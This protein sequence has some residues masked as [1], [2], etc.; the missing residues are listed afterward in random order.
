MLAAKISEISEKTNELLYSESLPETSKVKLVETVQKSTKKL[1]ED[2]QSADKFPREIEVIASDQS[3]NDAIEDVDNF[4]K[5]KKLTDNRISILKK[6]VQSV[7]Q[8]DNLDTTLNLE[9]NILRSEE[10]LVRDLATIIGK[11]KKEEGKTHDNDSWKALRKYCEYKYRRI[12]L[13][14]PSNEDQFEADLKWMTAQGE[15]EDLINIL[16]VKR[17]PPFT[18][19]RITELITEAEK[20]IC[21]REQEKGTVFGKYRI[22]VN[23]NLQLEKICPTIKV[24]LVYPAFSV[25]IA[26]EETFLELKDFYPIEQL[27]QFNSPS[28][29]IEQFQKSENLERNGIVYYLVVEFDILVPKNWEELIRGTQAEVIQPIGGSKVIIYADNDQIA[30]RI[31][32]LH[33]VKEV[34][35][36]EPAIDVREHYLRKK[37]KQP[38]TKA[39]IAEARLKAAQNPPQSRPRNIP[40]PGILIASF[41]T[42]DD[43]KKAAHDLAD[44]GIRIA[45]QPGMTTLVLD[46]NTLD[47]PVESL[48]IIG[49]QQGLSSL[50]EKILPTLFNNVARKL[51]AQEVIPSNP[52][53]N[54]TSLDLTGKGEIIAVADTGLDTGEIETLHIDFHDKVKAIK[55]LPITTFS[56]E[57]I[58]NF[59]EQEEEASD[60][61]TGHGTHVAG[62]ILGSGEQARR[63]GESSSPKGMAPEA[64]LIFQAMEKTPK[65]TLEGILFCL[66]ELRQ[67]PPQYGLMGIP[68]DLLDLFQPAYDAGARI[69]SNSWGGGRLRVY[70]K[71]CTDLDKFIW[72]NKD[73]LVVVAATNQGRQSASVS[74]E[75]SLGSVNS[76]GVAKNCLTVG[77]SENN[78]LGEFNDTYGKRYHPYFS[79]PPFKDDKMVDR[80]D[81]IAAFSSRGPCQDGRCKPDLVA[82]GTFVLS[83]RSS[84]IADNNFADGY[85]PPAK[86]HYM[87]MS[88]TSMATPLVAGC[89][90]LVRQY[91]R[92][93][94]RIAN[95]TAAIVKATLIHS[96]QYMNYRYAHSSSKPWADNEQ[97]WGRVDLRT[98][99]NPE[100]PT[101][102]IFIDQAEGLTTGDADE[103]K[104][105]VT[106]AKVR[107]RATLIYTDFPFIKEKLKKDENKVQPGQEIWD[108]HLV[109]NLNLTLNPPAN[110]PYRRYYQGND[111]ENTGKIDNCN[112]VE[113]CIVDA[114][115]VQAGIWTINVAAADVKKAPQDYALVIS[116]GITPSFEKVIYREQ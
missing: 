66:E 29:L 81:D 42:P 38:V 18:S 60:K 56:K 37:R 105:E 86:N 48:E 78:R 7:L 90:A 94:E 82:P 16:K 41:F 45:D 34:T 75:I 91:L 114:D 33:Q 47:N 72:D 15:G 112:N 62:S 30:T 9:Y 102:V 44:H 100:D 55:S 64:K 8:I 108:G 10:N 115:K 71:K 21:N 17:R 58:A 28:E 80:I 59:E 13:N 63:L 14:K 68:D 12:S 1:T 57:H 106:D 79:H 70:S 67:N 50:E 85:Y 97:G 40:I 110:Y 53:P 65:W 101:K 35:R 74:S 92:E 19:G 76:P 51:I 22:F 31:A 46:V 83:T 87:Y 26:T 36:Y 23:H 84:Q 32:N 104:I 98:V 73:F 93:K 25:V 61:H 27:H 6:A 2:L 99:L 5:L 54:D 95:P 52:I 89:A 43:R 4:S 111:F 20:E 96:A 77:A 116:G 39:Q 107:L 69:H 103:Y 109:N 3:S 113:G 88:G 49:N 11:E 24:E